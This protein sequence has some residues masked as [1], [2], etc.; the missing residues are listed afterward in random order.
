MTLR[1]TLLLLTPLNGCGGHT[2]SL[3]GPRIHA[4]HVAI[5]APQDGDV[6]ETTDRYSARL[7]TAAPLGARAS[8]WRSAPRGWPGCSRPA[9]PD[10]FRFWTR[11]ESARF[12]DVVA[13]HEPRWHALFAVALL[14]GL[15]QG[16]ILALD[17]PHV[18]LQARVIDVCQNVSAGRIGTPKSGIRR[19]VPLPSTLVQILAQHPRRLDTPI[20]FPRP[21][22]PERIEARQLGRVLARAIRRC[23]ALGAAVPVIRFH[24]LR[25]SYASQLVMAGVPL[26]AIQEYLGHRSITT[27]LRYAHLSPE[28]RAGYVEVLS[29]EGG[30]N[31]PRMSPSAGPAWVRSAE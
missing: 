6:F 13:A 23:E 28:A 4:P 8:S 12:L 21:T 26:R 22:A 5:Q 27:T 11:D 24:D 18:D 2:Q 15:R 14:A 17:W 3:P 19:L 7:L 1:S 20:V 30:A 25:H 9:P 29:L 10:A 16:E 31:V